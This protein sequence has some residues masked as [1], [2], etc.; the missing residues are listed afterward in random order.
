MSD[1]EDDVVAVDVDVDVDAVVDRHLTTGLSEDEATVLRKTYG[2]NTVP[3]PPSA[4]LFDLIAE[5]FEDRL[6]RILVG[7]AVLS[8]V[9]E[10]GSSSSGSGHHHSSLADFAEPL[11]ICFLLVVNA[12]VGVWQS[13]SA[14][15][16][17]EALKA[18]QP[19]VCTV[20]R[21]RLRRKKTKTT[22]DKDDD[23]IDVVATEVSEHPSDDLVPGD[24]IVLRTGDRVPADARLIR[25]HNGRR[26]LTVDETCLTG[27]SVPVEKLLGDE[28]LSRAESTTTTTTIIQ[29]QRGTVFAGTTVVSGAGIALVVATGSST[30]F[31]IIRGGVLEAKSESRKT[32]LTKQLDDF[33]DQLTG[34]IGL[35]CALVWISSIPK[36]ME[37]SNNGGIFATPFEGMVYYAKVAV[38]LGV[39]AIPEGLP[40]VITLCL[41]L[42]TRRM[43]RRNVIV[44]NL[45]SVETLGCVS[46]ICSDK[47]GTLTTNEM[48]VSSLVVLERE[49]REGRRRRN[50]RRDDVDVEEEGRRTSS[51]STR[52]NHHAV[53][54]TVE[55]VSYSPIGRIPGLSSSTDPTKSSS[56]SLWDVLA[57]ASLCN[58]A[59]IVGNDECDDEDGASTTTTTTTTK[60]FERN[61][62][63]TE[64]A[65]CVLAEKLGTV[66]DDDD[67]GDERDLGGR[68]RPASAVASRHVDRWRERHPKSA[69]LEFHRDR[70]SMSVLAD[71]ASG[72]GKKKRKQQA[73]N[74]LLVKGAANMVLDRCTHV[75]YLDGSVA[76][77]TGS[78]RREL[79]ATVTD[80]AARP[81]RCLALATKEERLPPSLRTF[82]PDGDNDVREHPLLSDPSRYE[83][84]ESGLTLVGLVGIKDPARP[85]VAESIRKC[86]EAGIRVIVITGDARD[87]AVAI[88]KEINVLPSNGD[89]DDGSLKAFEGQ[90]FFLKP[91]EEQLSIL[92]SGNI[93][94]CRAQP[95]D[96]QALIK[97]L[98]DDLNEIPA[99]TGDG[100][101]DAPAL[102]QA[103]IGV[104]M[105]TGTAVSKEA[106]DMVL[107]D[108]DFSTIVS[109]VEEG[110]TIY[111][112]M[113]AFICFL[114]S[115]NI[116]EICAIFFA[117]LLGFPE[118]LTAMHL[119]WVNLV[120]DG[121]PATALGFNPPSPTVLSEKPRPPDEPILTRWLLVRYLLTGLYVGVAT[122]GVFAHHYLR[123]GITLGQL[124]RWSSCGT[125][126]T[127][128]PSALAAAADGVVNGP[129]PCATLFRDDGRILPQ[130]L[131][132]TTLV[133]MEMLKALSAVSVNESI[134][135][136]PP[137][138][139]RWLLLGVAGPFLL[140]LSVLYSAKLGLP[141]FGEAFGMVPLTKDDWKAVLMWSS[142]ILLV[143]ELLKF[144]GRRL[145]SK[146]EK[147]AATAAAPRIDRRAAA[148][149]AEA[150]VSSF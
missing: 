132:L 60:A 3:E 13:R 22:G 134:F 61:G 106:S 90:E 78:L 83:S 94:F 21:R 67:D 77:I 68:R 51:S 125:S 93:V 46:V 111:S 36:M 122:I 32:P 148:A 35:I 144:V 123:R 59:T 7:V 57:V 18:M 52:R 99:M 85:E 150:T 53:E 96:K 149:A 143:D 43:A 141:G 4:S 101:N 91:R 116:G 44:R 108:D 138:K 137:W 126:W 109:A 81:L 10:A 33:G 75:R 131:S 114:I 56:S 38:A 50:N 1:S 15:S 24:L 119:L 128:P 29:S 142:P 95:S 74:R 48:T 82:R 117:T 6:V 11:V 14:G 130:T 113:Q 34:L 37:S 136:V 42:G 104:A 55:G 76:K 100:V 133:C 54:Y 16:S 17:L 127:P 102:Q 86:T 92:A 27:E 120:T 49:R 98:Q 39:A 12:T 110:R 121:P 72:G 115:C 63:P 66:L 84:I 28:G 97:M 5:Q 105:G 31:G 89:D 103:A 80:M 45:P 107:A 88:A 129:S 87:T 146:E 71:F 139:N 112:N 118:P 23:E 64:A 79:E 41:S 47:T 40:A 26:S 73:R 62:E 69:T 145:R 65:L 70:K 135:R 140:H 147:A 25:Y 9:L 20:L 8:A 2:P 30:E 58:D 19:S 124:A